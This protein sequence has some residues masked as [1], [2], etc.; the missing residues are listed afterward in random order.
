MQA[1]LSV[2]STERS[3]GGVPRSQSNVDIARFVEPKVMSLPFFDCKLEVKGAKK[4]GD[5]LVYFTQ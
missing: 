3:I 2:T 4:L 5:Q 1:L